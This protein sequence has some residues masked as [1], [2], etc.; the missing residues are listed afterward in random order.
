MTTSCPI[1]QAPGTEPF[2]DT[3][4]HAS[5][6]TFSL[7]RCR[8]CGFVF[9]WPQP[10]DLNKYYPPFYRNYSSLSAHLLQTVQQYR[11]ESWA[12][13][14]GLAG[15]VLEIGCGDA[16]IL[17]ALCRRG[18]QAVGIER[19]TER[20]QFATHRQH[21]PIFVGPLEAI[22]PSAGF[23]LIILHEVLEHLRDPM[24]TLTGSAV[25]LKP[26]GRMLIEVPNL[27]SWQ[28]RATRRHWLHLDVPR[29]LG[30]FTP[31]SL[32]AAME[33][34]GLRVEAIRF[35][36]LEYDPF[37][38]IESALNFLGFPQNTL[39][40]VVQRDQRLRLWSPVV[41]LALLLAAVLA[42]PSLL[43]ALVSWLA[44][45]GAIMEVRAVK[46]SPQ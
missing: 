9:T 41:L 3:R 42:V 46:P 8:Q 18:W 35:T 40:R 44:G 37:G 34:A 5:G 39:L 28:F 45:Q 33:R 24:T 43:L 38:W 17:A 31:A 10:A 21:V 1:C 2:L 36:S 29:H 22:K 6:E 4:D 12:K 25:R 14:L 30:H 7:Q 16:W 15:R 11:T 23:D 26:G 19:T 20:A 27:A 32:T 13:S